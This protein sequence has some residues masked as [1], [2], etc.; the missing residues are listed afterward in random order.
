MN[1][2]REI[3][4]QEQSLGRL[5]KVLKDKL[6]TGIWGLKKENEKFTH[7]EILFLFS[8]IFQMFGIDYI[9]EIRQNFPD[10]ICIKDDK[11]Y[12][13]EL[14]P[15]L[16]G[17]SEHI[18]NKRHDLSKCNCIICWKDDLEHY[19]YIRQEIDKYNI[20][21]IELKRLYEENKIKDRFKSYEWKRKDF[22]RL[23]KNK[24]LILKAFILKNKDILSTDEISDSTELKGKAL[25]GPLG[26]LG[27]YKEPLINKHPDGWQLN[28]KY[29]EN[30]I[31][32]LKRFK[33]I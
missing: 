3:P 32:V 23:P 8:R 30:I 26:N 7:E 24:L 31:E 16:S 2:E 11:E 17:F 21:V 33:Y 1:V 10:C 27:V 4:N 22:E 13:I 12:T 6:G 25:G 5:R 18:R 28:K 15:V 19:N 9:K 20:E 29:K 14:E